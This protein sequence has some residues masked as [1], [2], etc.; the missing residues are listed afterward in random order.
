MMV[1]RGGDWGGGGAAGRRGNFCFFSGSREG[2]SCAN[3]A[4]H[5]FC[6]STIPYWKLTGTWHVARAPLCSPIPAL[7]NLTCIGNRYLPFLALL[8]KHKG[9]IIRQ[10]VP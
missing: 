5:L 6:S 4:D 1:Q 10:E 8:S 9:T 7:Y 2:F 3:C